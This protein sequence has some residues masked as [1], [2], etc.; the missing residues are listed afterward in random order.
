MNV[1]SLKLQYRKN[2]IR[3]PVPVLYNNSKIQ[4]EIGRKDI[5]ISQ[6]V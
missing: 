4:A 1:L 3:V 6:I 2:V 5:D